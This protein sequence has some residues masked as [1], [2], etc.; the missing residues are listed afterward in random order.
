MPRIA[1]GAPGG[2]VYHVLN[3]GN[4]RK[5]LF[6]KPA[7]YAAFQDLLF[8]VAEAVPVRI[9]AWCLMPNHWHLVLWPRA[10][11]QLSNFMLRLT[12]A[13]VR[14]HHAHY[15]TS[16]GGHLYQGR[17]KSFPVQDDLHFLVLCR[18]VE[19]NPLRAGLVERDAARWRWSSLWAAAGHPAGRGRTGAAKG[20]D[21]ASPH[22][23]APW[24][25]ERPADWPAVVNAA[26]P[27]PDL[28]RVQASVRRGRPFGADAWVHRTAERLGLQFTLRDRGRPK[29]KMTEK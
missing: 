25:V 21:G 6:H 23:P 9:L 24:P 22:Q 1:R 20:A 15:H 8:E 14:R 19:A 11:G 13:H 4:G 5:R 26:L 7:D 17:Y 28:E 27:K 29:K 18:Y 2:Q 16:A 3:R 10:D 12:T